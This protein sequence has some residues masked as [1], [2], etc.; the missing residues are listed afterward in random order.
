MAKSKSQY[1][2]SQC[3]YTTSKW[4]GRCEECGE[5]NTFTEQVVESAG[6]SVVAKSANS[7]KAL[8][9]SAVGSSSG[10]TQVKRLRTEIS[11]LDIV[12]GGGYFRR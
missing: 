6:A 4:A 2:C 11:D 1:V 5:W 10:K 3:G 9:P 7:G 8:S 12:L